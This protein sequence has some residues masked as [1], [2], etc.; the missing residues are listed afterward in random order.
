VWNDFYS[1]IYTV[2]LALER[3]GGSTQL[4]E[5]VKQQL[6][7]EAKF[8][9]AF[10][11][12]YLVNLYGDVP[13]ALQTDYRINAKLQRTS[14]NLVYQQIIA[15]LKDAQTL[16]TDNYFSADAK[17]PTTERLRPNKWTATALLARAYLYTS[18]WTNSEIQA[19]SIISTNS[20][21]DTGS[22]NNVFLKSSKEAIWQLQP[23][24]TAWNT[25]DAKV[26]II[27]TAGPTS[28]STVSGY[29]V[30]LSSQLLSAFEI[31]DKRKINWIDSVTVG[32]GPA[33]ATYYYPYKYKSATLNAPVT[34]YTMVLRLGEQYLIRAEARAQLN[35]IAE[36]LSDL[37]VIRRRA[38]LPDAV[39]SDQTTLLNLIYHERQVELFTEWG[40]RWLDLKRT[41]KVDEVMSSYAP[42]KGTT[43]SPNW[44]LY[45]IPL[46]DI[47]QNP[48]L[49]QNPGY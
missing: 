22:L 16:L 38:G 10:L 48:N 29:P 19:N 15:D 30:Y 34:E 4:T 24:N 42:Q 27:P 46:Y 35:K 43:W 21:Y 11:Y 32:S 2:N 36:G 47:T 17:T 49:T 12:F 31:A 41:G 7:G 8:L 39:A 23:V 33:S 5:S 28:I 37:N 6:M 1:K 3:L 18:D 20:K 9:H 40:H 44:A 14:K 26:F 13:L 45:P 25:E